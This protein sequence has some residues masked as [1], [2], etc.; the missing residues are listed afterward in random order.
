MTHLSVP[1]DQI[2]NIVTMQLPNN[3]KPQPFY[4]DRQ[5]AAPFNIP[6]GFSFIIT[7]VIVNPEV[8]GF[9][10]QQFFL[11]VITIDGGRS[12][13]IRCE[14][15]TTHY[16]FAGGLVA[17]DPNLPSPGS[18]GIN[19]RNTTFSTGP[20]EVQLLG[21]FVKA[22]TGLGVGKLFS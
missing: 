3:N 15:R 12:I 11:V 13:T 6:A 8:T 2:V 19:A 10:S 21:Y 22:A 16:P 5:S 14:G 9:A 18:K 20:A 4:Y 7:D 1:I 17:P